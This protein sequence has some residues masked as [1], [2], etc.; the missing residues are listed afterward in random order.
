MTVI[1]RSLRYG[2]EIEDEFD[3]VDEATRFAY[4]QEEAGS[5][6]VLEVVDEAGGVLLTRAELQERM[7]AE[8]RGD[9]G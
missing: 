3:T 4:V 5:V 1:L 6:S 7:L 8:W 2:A 9:E